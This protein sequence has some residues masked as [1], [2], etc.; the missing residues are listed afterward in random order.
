[1]NDF[2]Q[3]M[4][5]GSGQPAAFVLSNAFLDET[6]RPLKWALRSMT[7]AE[8]TRWA[9]AGADPT[10][11]LE[12]L[13][14]TLTSPRLDDPRLRAM[15]EEKRGGP[16]TAAQALGLLLTWDELRALTAAFKS[17]NGLTLPFWNRVGQMV[18][19]L[20]N[21]SDTRARLMHL[22][23]QNHH[24]SPRDY[25]AHTEQEQAF[26]A[27]SDIVLQK[28]CARAQQRASVIKRPLK[29]NR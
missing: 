8:Q 12:L 18:D 4:Q 1:M 29:Q 6:G 7:R 13:A 15:L 22:A 27:A 9:R 5:P 28:E 3:L 20:E 11:Q 10:A 2:N 26:I 19:L 23:L 24:I 25:F 17:L 16:V 21:Q 14:Q